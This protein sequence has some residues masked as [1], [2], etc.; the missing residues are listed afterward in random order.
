MP[1]GPAP[2]MARRS[3]VTVFRSGQWWGS[4]AAF[5]DRLGEAGEGLLHGALGEWFEGLDGG[6]CPAVRLFQ[7]SGGHRVGAQL[8]DRGR[9]VGVIALGVEGR[10]DVAFDA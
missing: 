9:D 6:V 3:V 7:G 8:R 2:T 5:D 1:A 4:V 10:G